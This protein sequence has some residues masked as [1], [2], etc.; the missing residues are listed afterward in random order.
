MLI[1]I[2]PK[3]LNIKI[4]EL[5]QDNKDTPIKLAKEIYKHID[6]LTET[7]QDTQLPTEKDFDF[8]PKFYPKQKEFLESNIDKESVVQS[9]EVEEPTE[10]FFCFSKVN[11]TT[12]REK[13]H[14]LPWD[15]FTIGDLL[16]LEREPTNEFD[17]NA[18][19]VVWSR[20][21]HI[22]YIP[23]STA[24][25]VSELI[26]DGHKMYAKINELTGGVDGKEAKGIN[27]KLFSRGVVPTNDDHYINLKE[28]F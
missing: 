14:P 15:E 13:E 9:D 24:I 23:K 18:V 4:G 10:V 12:F 11:G 1:E 22:G 5:I 27:I 16:L 26:K 3:L 21:I 17:K 28:D 7:Y 20:G 6:K 2:D 25:T 8:V 19:K